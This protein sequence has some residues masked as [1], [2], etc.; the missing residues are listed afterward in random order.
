VL[1]ARP[2]FRDGASR[3]APLPPSASSRSGRPPGPRG[4]GACPPRARPLANQTVPKRARRADGLGG[5]VGARPSVVPAKERPEVLRPLVSSRSWQKNTNRKKQGTRRFS[6]S[7]K[8]SECPAGSQLSPRSHSRFHCSIS[9]IVSRSRSIARNTWPI[10]RSGPKT[11][12]TSAIC[13]GVRLCIF[14]HYPGFA[15]CPP[16]MKNG[17]KMSAPVFSM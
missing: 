14:T 2:R 16:A 7:L 1:K 8:R 4:A 5:R 11:R 10:V 15:G 13:S 3:A 6:V 17:P 9:R 12:V